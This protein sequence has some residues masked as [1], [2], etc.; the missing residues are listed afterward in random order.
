MGGFADLRRTATP[1][2]PLACASIARRQLLPVPRSD[3][4][5]F[6]LCSVRGHYPPGRV[7]PL[8]AGEG[9]REPSS[10]HESFGTGKYVIIEWERAYFDLEPMA[11]F[12]RVTVWRTMLADEI[13]YV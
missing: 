11:Y 3:I 1:P 13:I 8:Q 9:H 6:P 7:D 2:R 10:D 12:G 4:A 5:L